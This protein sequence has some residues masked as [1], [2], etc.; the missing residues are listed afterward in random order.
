MLAEKRLWESTLV[1][2]LIL[3]GYVFAFDRRSCRD[4]LLVQ[5]SRAMMDLQGSV[6]VLARSGKRQRQTGV[7]GKDRLQNLQ[8]TSACLAVM[9]E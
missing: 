7:K 6:K 9:P 5:G 1:S 4:R 3:A 8:G 2:S